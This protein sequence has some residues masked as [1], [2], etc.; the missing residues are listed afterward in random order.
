MEFL[1]YE[2]TKQLYQ[3]RL[4]EKI[5]RRQINEEDDVER[6]WEKIRQNIEEAAKESLGTRKNKK[7]WFRVEINKNVKRKEKRT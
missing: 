5:E 1:W 4:K 7:P 2:L 3:A 6:S